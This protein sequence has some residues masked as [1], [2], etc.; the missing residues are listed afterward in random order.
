MEWEYGLK[1]EMG[2]MSATSVGDDAK[3]TKTDAIIN[4]ARGAG[5]K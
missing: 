5:L 1:S 4:I 2:F 3:P